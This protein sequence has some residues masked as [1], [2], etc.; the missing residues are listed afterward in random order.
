MNNEIF[1]YEKFDE[2]LEKL[3]LEFAKQSVSTPFQNYYWLKLW[4]EVIGFPIFDFELKI[5]VLTQNKKI[6][7]IFPMC[8]NKIYK[9]RTLQWIGGTQNDYMCPILIKN[10]DTLNIDFLDIWKKIL[11][12]SE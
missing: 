7:A 4:C 8:V 9:I 5:I 3:W 6:V 10:W 12:Q 11:L 1:I 2:K